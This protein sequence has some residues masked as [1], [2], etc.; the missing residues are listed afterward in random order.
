MRG[1]R[2]SLEA[3]GPV[4]LAKDSAHVLQL[5]DAPPR[6]RLVVADASRRTDEVQALVR[7]LKLGGVTR[8]TPVLVLLHRANGRAMVDMINAGAR[9]VLRRPLRRADVDG[10]LRR[11]LGPA[12]VPP[13]PGPNASAR[14][15]GRLEI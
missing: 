11:A 10:A 15:A 3:L 7:E 14:R 6:P 12:S 5:V 13:P 8:T 1:L 4:R 9:A 2:A